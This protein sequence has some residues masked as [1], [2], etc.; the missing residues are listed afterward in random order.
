MGDTSTLARVGFIGLVALKKNIFR[1]LIVNLTPREVRRHLTRF[2]DK[3]RTWN[4]FVLDAISTIIVFLWMDVAKFVE[5][6]LLAVNC[7]HVGANYS[8]S[9]IIKFRVGCRSQWH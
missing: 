8:S 9:F 3:L 7:A 2:C 1:V 4:L 6:L 5:C